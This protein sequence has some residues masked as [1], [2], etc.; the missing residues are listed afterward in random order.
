MEGST[1]STNWDIYR[2]GNWIQND[3]LYPG[4][5]EADSDK[6]NNSGRK[7]RLKVSIKLF[8]SC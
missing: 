3:I 5:K 2:T 6:E 4:H 8:D 1:Q 7:M